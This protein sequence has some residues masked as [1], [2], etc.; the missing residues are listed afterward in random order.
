MDIREA[1]PRVLHTVDLI[2]RDG[3]MGRSLRGEKSDSGN[4]TG[5]HHLEDL[6]G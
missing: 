1:L 3:S 4:S 5:E 2:R 6:T